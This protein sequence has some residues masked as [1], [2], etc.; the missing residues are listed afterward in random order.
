MNMSVMSLG[1]RHIS[2]LQMSVL[3]DPDW[4]WLTYSDEQHLTCAMRLVTGLCLDMKMN[5]S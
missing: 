3:Q 5:L 4:A 2:N 1:G